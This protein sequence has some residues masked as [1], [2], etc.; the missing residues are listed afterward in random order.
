[1]KP[2]CAHIGAQECLRNSLVKQHIS[3]FLNGFNEFQ[4]SIQ[5]WKADG[6]ATEQCDAVPKPPNNLSSTIGMNLRSNL[7]SHH[8]F[9]YSCSF[10]LKHERPTSSW[11]LH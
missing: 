8:K 2:N 1:M 4:Q 11:I 7:P 9:K 5:T 10:T 6:V 3:L